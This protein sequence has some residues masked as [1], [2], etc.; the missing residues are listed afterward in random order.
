LRFF[1]GGVHP[2]TN[3][4][5]TK[6]L[7]IRQA[8]V[9][10][11]VFIPLVQHTGVPC[12]STVDVGDYVKKGS[13]IG[14]CN[15]FVCA[16]IHS[17]VSGKVLKIENGLHPVLD[18]CQGIWIENNGKEEEEKL[19]AL[20]FG[21]CDVHT[22]RT[23]I[24][25]AGIVGM[26]GAGFPTH[27]KIS[28]PQDKKI[29][30]LIINGAECEP[31]ITADYRLMIENPLCIWNGIK[32][33]AKAVGYPNPIKKIVLATEQDKKGAAEIMLKTKPQVDLEV[34]VNTLPTMY[35][36]GAEKQLIFALKRK[37]VPSGGLPMDV[38]A[39]VQNVGTCFAVHQALDEGTPLYERIVTVS[40]RGVRQPS[41]LR[42]RIGTTFR[43]C[44]EQCGGLDSDAYS[45][46][47]GGPMM[48]ITQHSL[49][50]PVIKGTSAILIL[51]KED[52]KES[53]ELQCIR[54]G[55]C[56]RA[57]PIRLSPTFLV[58]FVKKEDMELAKKYNLLD[59]IEC[60]CC[61]FICPSHINLVQWLK[62][63][64]MLLRKK[65]ER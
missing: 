36:Q 22:I 9:P 8:R 50:V 32:W 30:C 24:Q 4:E 7:P 62:F 28:P 35:P 5:L 34:Q 52:I 25:Q 11:K 57:C 3:K 16:Y 20:D 19:E 33:M 15:R 21:S 59:C 12:E 41:N 14:K 10:S 54:C 17:S 58:S 49:D 43:D 63:G 26:G 65:H 45:V 37:E 61:G 53:D 1:Y 44:I 2:H 64:K 29:D 38:G 23:R 55:R 13:I 39:V 31:Y 6:T 48:G 56:I 42:V 27:V 40:G 18:Y 60:G 46:I 51:R 47:S